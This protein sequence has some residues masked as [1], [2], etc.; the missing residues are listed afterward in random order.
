MTVSSSSPFVARI[1]A[2]LNIRPPQVEAVAKLLEE[3]GTV[4]FIARYRKE[5]TGSLDE[6]AITAIRDRLD[7]LAELEKRRTTILKSLTERELLTDALKKSILAA[8]SLTVL[9]DIYAPHRPKRRTRAT[10]AKERGLEPLAEILLKNPSADIMKEA[11]KY[12]SSEKEVTEIE[13]A[14]AG[15]RDIIAE[16][17]ADHPESR[18]AVRKV[19]EES[20]RVAAKV[21]ASKKND[22]EAAKYRDYFEFDEPLDQIPSH[23]LLA[24][25]RGESEGFLKL[26]IDVEEEQGIRVAGGKFLTGQTSDQVH[27]AIEDGCKR[28]LFP[29]METEMRNASRKRADEEAI[30]VF[31]SNLR[32]L[33][34]ASPLG[35][36]R[37]LAIDPGFRTGCKTVVLD[38]QGQLLHNDVIYLVGSDRQQLD[39]IDTVKS[40][41]KK[42]KIEAI[43]IGNGTAS[44]ETEKFVKG[45]GIDPSIPVVMVNESGASIYSASDVARKEFPDQDITVR[46][47]VSIGRRLMDPLAELVKIDP[48]SIGVGQYQHDV[49]QNLLKSA[50]TDTVESCVNAVG[51]EVNTASAELLSHVAGLNKT[52]A[53]NIVAYR[54]ENGPFTSRAQLKKVPRLGA[55]AYEQAAG[56]LR[57]RDA[58]NPLDASA[59]HPERYSVVQEMA[60]NVGCKIED[61]LTT[62]QLRNRINL[63]DYV[64]NDVGMPTLRDIIDE[65]ARPGRDP[66]E[67]FETVEFAE[68][69]DKPSDLKEGMKLTGVVT[70]VTAFGAFVDVGVH[71]DGLVHISQLADQYVADP[72]DVVKVG[73]KV[74][75]RVVEVD[76]NRNRISLSMKA[77]APTGGSQRQNQPKPRNQN[78]RPRRQNQPR[79]EEPAGGNDWFSAAIE[80]GKK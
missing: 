24:I 18:K 27:L 23:R 64:R 45:I 31:S 72:A 29:S 41:V 34:L 9:E 8:D 44:R 13:E 16:Q 17:V 4:P 66:R 63:E 76:L 38:A 51:V 15:A 47:A 10:I 56:F 6:V 74:Q 57:I 26:G 69:I 61:L 80:K 77:E 40:L 28:L 11:E 21:V 53:E 68:G 3:G 1:A 7:Q 62:D 58:K 39:A 78:N 59:V 19:Y 46:G 2:E 70:N 42:Y 50:L 36:K 30:R 43:A 20:S 55:K 79:R 22:P 12:L 71:Q 25:R 32:E 52:I 73:Q 37:T 33:L 67:K 5:A 75:V 35:Q 49:D 14:L 60:K 48:K 65:L 54:N